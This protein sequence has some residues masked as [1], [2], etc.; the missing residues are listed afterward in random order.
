[1]IT[2]SFNDFL[3]FLGALFVSIGG[4]SVVV[5]ALSKWFGDF[6]SKRLLDNYN[7][8]YKTE[9]EILK[10]NYQRELESTK[11]ELD[12]AKSL[13]LRYSEKQ[14][15]L[16]NELWKVLLYTKEQADALWELAEINKIPSFI[17]QINLTKKAVDNSLLLIEEDHYN[18]LLTLINQFERFQLGKIALIELRN[19][20]SKQI[21]DKNITEI[22]IQQTIEQN[23]NWKHGYDDLLSEIGKSFRLQIKG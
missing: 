22:E 6:L 21:R 23:R 19:S 15:D 9:L 1:M 17:E 14:F 16:Y 7:N 20:T 11:V 10:A 13:F 5:V 8:Q 3:Q 4:A 18:K 12:K 2:L